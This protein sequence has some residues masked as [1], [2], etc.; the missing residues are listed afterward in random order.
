MTLIL[1]A[2]R[3]VEYVEFSYTHSMLQLKIELERMQPIKYQMAPE[4]NKK[5]KLN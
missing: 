5:Q 1:L 4:F 3:M 2:F